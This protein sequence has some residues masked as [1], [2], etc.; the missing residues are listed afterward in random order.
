[1][2]FGMETSPT[3]NP[4]S[5]STEQVTNVYKSVAAYFFKEHSSRTWLIFA[6]SIIMEGLVFIGS[7]AAGTGSFTAIAR[8]IAIV[9]PVALVV[10]IWRVWARMQKLFF[11]ELAASLG[12][13]YAPRGDMSTVS[14]HL[15]SKGHNRKMTN[16]LTGM[17]QGKPIRLYDYRY[18]IG[19]GKNEQ[20]FY[21][22]VGEVS[23]D[24]T[25]PHLIVEPRTFF[26][27][28]F[29]P[30][31]LKAL[32][33]EG[34]FNKHFNVYATEGK[35]IEALQVLQPDTMAALLDDYKELGFECF[36]AK[37]YLYRNGMLADNRDAVLS[38]LAL[39]ERFYDRLVPELTAVDG[40]P[41]VILSNP[42]Q[43]PPPD[44]SA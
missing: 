28:P 23:I 18:T 33:L 9:I 27:S 10:A 5:P 30:T 21:Y 15:F 17:Y 35:E 16:V 29:T 14:G 1:M 4:D 24:G 38:L 37:T 19:S 36:G 39:L 8:F 41:N 11:N 3:P 34:D 40:H 42:S 25:L 2:L 32:S 7:F 31:G 44:P 13:S 26:S 43:S 20:T 22:V 12:F 6:L